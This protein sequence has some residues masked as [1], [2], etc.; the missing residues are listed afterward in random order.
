[1]LDKKKAFENKENCS[2]QHSIF[3]LG[4]EKKYVLLLDWKLVETTA[5]SCV[6]RNFE[7]VA[8]EIFSWELVAH[9]FFE[10]ILSEI[11]Y[12]FDEYLMKE[13]YIY[14]TELQAWLGSWPIQIIANA[15]NKLRCREG[16]STDL[17]TMTM[18]P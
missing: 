6:P 17:D 13:M 2:L 9:D 12:R 18:K 16:C 10:L 4:Y 15:Y 8:R 5:L 14:N 3:I 1:M 11:K 7:I